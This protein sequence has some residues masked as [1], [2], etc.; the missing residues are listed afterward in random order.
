MNFINILS[1][2]IGGFI[3]SIA[4]YLMVISID[5]R[6]KGPLPLGTLTVNVVGSLLL[7]LIIGLVTKRFPS[8][9]TLLLALGTGLCGG[10]TTFSAFAF[11][12][13]NLWLQRPSSALIY[14][15]ISV[16]SG[17]AAVGIGLYLG[18]AVA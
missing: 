13:F 1:I 16:V 8:N 14:I 12:N 2:G 6:F 4:R 5:H 18:K 10:F 7:G 15:L 11:E 17:I 3:G 9:A